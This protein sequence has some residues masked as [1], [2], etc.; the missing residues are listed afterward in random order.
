MGVAYAVGINLGLPAIPAGLTGDGV[1]FVV[2]AVAGFLGR[3][4]LQ[5]LAGSSS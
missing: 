3:N 4:A 1:V 5:G 2:A